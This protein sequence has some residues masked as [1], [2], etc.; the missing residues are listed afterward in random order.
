MVATKS[1]QRRRAQNLI[2]FTVE[3]SR[4][5]NTVDFNTIIEHNVH[6]HHHLN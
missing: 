2:V 3:G 6:H 5:K 1:E 4:T